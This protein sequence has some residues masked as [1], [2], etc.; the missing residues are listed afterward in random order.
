MVLHSGI[1]LERRDHL[2]QELNQD[3]SL[4]LLGFLDKHLYSNG[5]VAKL[6]TVKGKAASMPNALKTYGEV[7]VYIRVFLISTL[8]GGEWAASRFSPRPTRNRAIV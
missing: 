7:E 5:E 8:V 4:S 6:F 3:F 1:E 2:G